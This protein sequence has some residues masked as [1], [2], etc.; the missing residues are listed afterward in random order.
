MLDRSTDEIITICKNA[1]PDY[2]K[3][4][5]QT[6][7]FFGLLGRPG[8]GIGEFKIILDKVKKYEPNQAIY[9]IYSFHLGQDFTSRLRIF[10]QIALFE[11]FHIENNVELTMFGPKE[12]TIL[13]GDLLDQK[14]TLIMHELGLADERDELLPSVST[15]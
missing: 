6:R 7:F 1:I 8:D 14:M 15:Y 12:G 2:E 11:I 5:K 10:I 4:V 3:A 9:E 13:P